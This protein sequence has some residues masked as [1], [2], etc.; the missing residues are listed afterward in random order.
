MNIRGISLLPVVVKIYSSILDNVYCNIWKTTIF[1]STNKID[2]KGKN[3]TCENPCSYCYII[4]TNSTFVT[5]IDVH[6]AV[7]TVT[8]DND[9]FQYWLLQNGVDGYFYNMIIT[10]YQNTESCVRDRVVSSRFR[11]SAS[12]SSLIKIVWF[13]ECRQNRCQGNTNTYEQ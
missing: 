12:R 2:L 8:E 7:N 3:R 9:L 4:Q 6:K 13:D 10:I 1:L 5:F 11:G